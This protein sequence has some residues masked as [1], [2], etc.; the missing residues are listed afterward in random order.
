MLVFLTERKRRARGWRVG[1]G[2]HRG[3]TTSL[4]CINAAPIPSLQRLKH[5]LN[6]FLSSLGGPGRILKTLIQR[7]L[8]EFHDPY[9]DWHDFMMQPRQK[10]C[11]NIQTWPYSTE[12]I[13]CNI[14][15]RKN[16]F[17]R[18]VQNLQNHEG[19]FFEALEFTHRQETI[20]I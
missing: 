4:T 17:P 20:T 15:K 18:G 14:K 10:K 7:H 1:G 11:A 13:I 6:K 8:S 12:K 5:F 3:K 2:F 19:V 9:F 16:S